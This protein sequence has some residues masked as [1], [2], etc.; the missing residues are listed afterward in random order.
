MTETLASP[1]VAIDSVHTRLGGEP[2]IRATPMFSLPKL[3]ELPFPIA[4]VRDPAQ[5]TQVSGIPREPGSATGLR[6]DAGHVARVVMARQAAELRA[7]LGLP[8]VLATP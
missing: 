1:P 4:L 5:V 6:N 7:A 3:R 2:A 8:A